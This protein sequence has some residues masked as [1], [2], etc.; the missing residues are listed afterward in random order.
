MLGESAVTD[1]D[2]LQIDKYSWISY[3]NEGL[4]KN[5]DCS[6]NKPC[7]HIVSHP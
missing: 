3:I 7:G 6:I 2:W 5:K 4:F 1:S